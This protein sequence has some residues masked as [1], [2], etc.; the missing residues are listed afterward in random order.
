MVG[1]DEA[2]GYMMIDDDLVNALA[3]SPGFDSP[4]L[5]IISQQ[6]QQP[7]PS[8]P[9][10]IQGL[11]P[12]SQPFQSSQLRESHI[13]PPSLEPTVHAAHGYASQ[14]SLSQSNAAVSSQLMSTLTPLVVPFRLEI[15]VLVFKAYLSWYLC[16][17]FI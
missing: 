1:E 11:L 10:R 3:M 15:V 5:T 6:Q 9:L 7:M 2:A 17:L 14:P 12:R 13:P 4:R 16:R 8:S